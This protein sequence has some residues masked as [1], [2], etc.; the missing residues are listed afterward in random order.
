MSTSAQF[1]SKAIGFGPAL[2]KTT[3]V[4]VG[5]AAFAT[6]GAIVAA[7]RGRGWPVK[8]WMVHYRMMG[9]AIP[10][11]LLSARGGKIY[12]FEKGAK[13]HWIG[14]GTSKVARRSGRRYQTRSKPILGGNLDHPVVGPVWHDGFTGRPF[15]D[16]GVA[17]SEPARRKILQGAIKTTMAATFGGK[18]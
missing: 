2:Q 6:K 13:G 14:L 3:K 16:R 15:W 7:A 9:G 1:A 18:R 17:V 5:Q 8:P 11:A 4:A 12:M 10:S